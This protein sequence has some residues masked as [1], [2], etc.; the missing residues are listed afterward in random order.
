MV[1]HRLYGRVPNDRRINGTST[2]PETSATP[3]FTYANAAATSAFLVRLI[4][5]SSVQQQMDPASL[6]RFR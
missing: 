4:V 3:K 1:S 5:R 2:I 6:Q